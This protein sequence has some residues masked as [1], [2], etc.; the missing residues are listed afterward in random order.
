MVLISPNFWLGPAIGAWLYDIGGFFLPFMAVGSVCV[1]L[2]VLMI[3]TIP[4][5]SLKDKSTESELKPIVQQTSFDLHGEIS[6]SDE[7]SDIR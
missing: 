3:V 2:A 1:M 7:I 5:N 6:S 4:S